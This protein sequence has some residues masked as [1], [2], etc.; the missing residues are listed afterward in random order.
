MECD[1]CKNTFTNKQTLLNHQKTAKY[2][3][4]LQPANERLF[5]CESCKKELSTKHRLVTHYQSCDKHKEKLISDKIQTEFEKIISN[6]EEKNKA[7]EKQITEYKEQIKDLQDRLEN[8]AT[9][10]A[11]KP[12]YN[13]TN[14]GK[15]KINNYIQ[16]IAPIIEEELKEKSTN[17][18][19]DHIKKGSEGYA[20]YALQFPL[21]DRMICTDFSRR[22]VKFKNKDGDIITDIEMKSLAKKFFNS[23][24]ERNAEL[25]CQYSD[26]LKDQFGGEED[27]TDALVKIFEYRMCVN[28]ACDGDPTDFQQDFVKEICAKTIKE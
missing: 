17:L 27:V 6:L 7:Q 14:S 5:T 9:K 4:A 16:Q 13:T 20:Q 26:E 10:A 22:K 1:F 23:I 15:T 19:I 3:L 25:I 21:K 12:T 18:T 2:C 28:K 24:K 11:L 8:I